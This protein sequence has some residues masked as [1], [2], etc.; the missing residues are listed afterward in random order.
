[1]DNE[2]LYTQL[3][4]VNPHALTVR[5]M[6]R[7]TPDAL[8]GQTIRAKYNIAER[9]FR[10]TTSIKNKVIYEDVGPSLNMSGPFSLR[11]RRKTTRTID[12]ARQYVEARAKQIN[13]LKYDFNLAKQTVEAELASTWTGADT[14]AMEER[15]STLMDLDRE[16]RRSEVLLHDELDPKNNKATAM[17]IYLSHY[18]DVLN[19]IAAAMAPK[20]ERSRRDFWTYTR[21]HMKERTRRELHY[22]RQ[23]SDLVLDNTK[24]ETEIERQRRMIERQAAELAALRKLYKDCD[25]TK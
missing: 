25:R 24:K 14:D 10:V 16:L 3:V 19:R 12:D 11:A 1:M 4:K 8:A 22:A 7:D 20:R 18:I 2:P 6:F 23:M 9:T 5:D 17:T 13:Q 15:Q 21:K